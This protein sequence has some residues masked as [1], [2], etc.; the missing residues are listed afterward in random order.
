M[1]KVIYSF[2]LLAGVICTAM[3]QSEQIDSLHAAFDQKYGLDM[4]LYSGKK[5]SKEVHPIKGHPFWLNQDEFTAHV[6]IGGVAYPNQRLRYNL[7][8]QE[9]I[10]HYEDYNKL[11]HQIILNTEVIDSVRGK[12]FLFVKNALYPQINYPFLS[13]IYK[14]KL[15]CY[16]AVK[17]ELHFQSQ[18]EIIG[19]EFS[20]QEREYYLILEDKVY[21]FQKKN[22]FLRIFPKKKKR[23]IRKYISSRR[24]KFK[25]IS[26]EELKELI[27]FT[28]R[29]LN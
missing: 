1:R 9:F 11:P 29:I 26:D 7:Y 15:A 19:H 2:L 24:I 25:D 20:D 5:Y 27:A 16:A 18:G 10:L 12:D 23:A 4:A 17:K 21:P 22:T 3:G 14:E 6:F 28:E 13:V 8:K